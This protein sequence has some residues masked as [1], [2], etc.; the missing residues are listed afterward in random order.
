MLMIFCTVPLVEKDGKNFKE[1]LEKLKIKI[2]NNNK[3]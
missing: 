3:I 1:K 2:D